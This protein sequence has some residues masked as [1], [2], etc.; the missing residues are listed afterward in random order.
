MNR[1][2]SCRSRLEVDTAAIRANVLSL[3]KKSQECGLLGVVK[4]NAY[5][6]GTDI[7]VPALLECGVKILGAATLSEAVELLK[8]NVEVRILSG[9]MPEEIAPAVEFGVTLPVIDVETARAIDAEACR[10]KRKATVQIAIDTG[11]G[12]VGVHFKK[13][14]ESVEKILALENLNVTGMYSHFPKAEAGDADSLKQIAVMKEL[15]ESFPLPQYHL[16]ASEGTLF[17]PDASRPPFNLIRLGI[18]M[19]GVLPETELQ[20]SVRFKSRLA[21]VRRCP[22]GGSVSYGRLHKLASETLVGTVAAGYAD[23]VPLHLTNKGFFRV[24]GKLCPILGRVTMDY[25]MI[26][27]EGVPEAQVGD[28]VELFTSDRGD[29]LNLIHWCNYKKTHPW[30]ILCSISPRV[31][32]VS[33]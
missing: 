27:L 25:T 28:E 8:Y 15:A 9:I 4:A 18:G 3:Q 32:R 11:M 17:L 23:G 33:K 16:A 7:V 1:D 19:Y 22:A 14:R 10:Q 13:A 12:R 30:D 20:G 6:L 26:S 2:Y 5:G 31:K 21:A 29:A 24:N